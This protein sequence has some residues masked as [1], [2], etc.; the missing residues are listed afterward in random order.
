MWNKD[1]AKGKVEQTKGVV[2]QKV[3]ELLGD[4]ALEIEGE[5]DQ[6]TGKV[7]ETVGTAKRKVGEAVDVLRERGEESKG[8]DVTR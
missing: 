3:G 4:E 6:A 7:R 8:T 5:T 1:E 2:K